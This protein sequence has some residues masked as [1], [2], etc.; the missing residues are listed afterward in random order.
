M[1]MRR[2]IAPGALT[3]IVLVA[4]ATLA[5]TPLEA[6]MAS[7]MFVQL[8]ML[9]V[10]GVLLVKPRLGD[11]VA[12]DL[13]AAVAG[14]VLA[15]GIVTTWMIP[16]ALDLAVEHPLVDAAKAG[17]LLLAGATG[18]WAWHRA[19]AMLRVFALGNV[20][21]M[22]ATTGLLYLEAPVRVCTSYGRDDQRQTG[23]ALV[24]FTV[25][26][27]A[28]GLRRLPERSVPPQSTPSLLPGS[29]R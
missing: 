9:L 23:I 3:A 28:V 29:N 26:A 7:H 27:G 14:L 4:I 8:P 5:R 10:A 25:L 20:A 15:S 18:A 11:A 13:L 24:V 1:M 22:T 21:W 17:S 2:H 19:P 6:R 16:R 12:T